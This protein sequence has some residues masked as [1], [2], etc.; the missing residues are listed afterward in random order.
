MRSVGERRS[1]LDDG[2]E[3]GKVTIDSSAIG[4]PLAP[5]SCSSV[6]T[7]SRCSTTR[8]PRYR[9]RE[10]AAGTPARRGGRWKDRAGELF[11]ENRPLPSRI[12]S[13]A[14][15]ALLAP[16][17]LGPFVDVAQLTAGELRQ[18]VERGGRPHEVLAALSR[19]WPQR[20]PRCSCS[21][22][23]T[24]ADEATLDVLRLLGRRV[25]GFRALVLATYRDDEFDGSHPLRVVLGELARSRGF[26]PLD[27]ARLSAV[28]A[29]AGRLSAP[30]RTLLEA[31]TVAPPI[32]DIGVLEAIA[33]EATECLDEGNSQQRQAARVAAQRLPPEVAE[34]T[35]LD[36]D[37]AGSGQRRLGVLASLRLRHLIG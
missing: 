8:W 25:D 21:R 32:A 35:S 13:G 9:H 20:R 4:A 3:R 36:Q 27:V 2:P 33:G 19:N 18:L 5:S 34:L 11:C 30:A 10:G 29:R 14:C 17:P 22:I 16:R 26:L 37:V 31:L 1:R 6:L 12:L 28:L 15:E 7:I 23:C 24:G